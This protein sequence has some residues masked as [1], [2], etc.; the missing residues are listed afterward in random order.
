MLSL[1]SC[2]FG[3][4]PLKKRKPLHE[5]FSGTARLWKRLAWNININIAWKLYAL[6]N[7]TSLYIEREKC[8]GDWQD[9][10]LKNKNWAIYQFWPKQ[11]RKVKHW[12]ETAR[13]NGSGTAE[14][15][16]E[17]LLGT[18]HKWWCDTYRL[19]TCEKTTR[20]CGSFIRP[21]SVILITSS[22]IRPHALM[23][24]MLNHFL[25]PSLCFIA[26]HV[27]AHTGRWKKWSAQTDSGTSSCVC[28][29]LP[30]FMLPK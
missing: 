6:V 22:N 7:F 19:W 23:P 25:P 11:S 27:R 18:Q 15:S 12:D 26:V 30:T 14:R 13:V 5:L 28:L 8:L 1:I 4:C 17:Q 9:F 2:L 24:V 16:A 29:C 3:E 10:S 21:V 20:L